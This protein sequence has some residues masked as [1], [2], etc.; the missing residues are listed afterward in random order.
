[1]RV[2]VVSDTHGK[3]FNFDDALFET[4]KIDALIHLGDVEGEEYYY[5]S[6]CE[7]PSYVL[8]GNN[9][10]FS[11][12]SREMEIELGGKKIFLTHGHTYG[13][14]WSLESIS[15]EGR[16]RGVDIVMHGHTH[17]PY[18]KEIDGMLILNPG[19]LT[20]PRQEG[21]KPSYIVMEIDQRGCLK[22]DIRYLNCQ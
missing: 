11:Y 2:L 13:V 19:S 9:D 12:N 5:E 17:K 4:G 8:A 14:S 7:C 22:T 18:V 20:H 6:I 10:Y 15:R 21:R 3:H 1:M 16:R